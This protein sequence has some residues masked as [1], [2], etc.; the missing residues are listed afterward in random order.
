MTNKN[1]N[2]VDERGKKIG[3]PKS[4]I[5]IGEGNMFFIHCS[6]VSTF[7]II[8][9]PSFAHIVEK[10]ILYPLYSH[11]S[12]ERTAREVGSEAPMLSWLGASPFAFTVHPPAKT[13]PPPSS[14]RASAFSLWGRDSSRL[15]C[16]RSEADCL[17]LGKQLIYRL[18][19]S[20]SL[21]NIA[22]LSEGLTTLAKSLRGAPPPRAT[23]PPAGGA[24]RQGVGPGLGD[25][26]GVQAGGVKSLVWAAGLA[27]PQ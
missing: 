9:S 3:V 22:R 14:H 21:K 1:A 19:R 26:R 8:Q 20:K 7:S 13:F 15:L 27:A 2:C 6:E 4:L 18:F 23:L 24:R 5:V 25:T 17:A 16:N 12:S 11:I 10:F